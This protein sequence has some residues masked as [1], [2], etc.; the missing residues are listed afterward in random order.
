[1]D[2]LEAIAR[3]HS[4]RQ[5]RPGEVPDRDVE[6]ILQAGRRAPSGY[7]LQN[8]EFVVVRDPDVIAQLNRVQDSFDNVPVVIG[9]VM[10]PGETPSGGSYWVEDCAA[11]V[12]NML[13]AITG[14]GYASVWVEG[15]LRRH[16]SWLKEQLGVPA[17]KRLL[18][19]L[20]VGHEAEPGE[21]AP[22]T[23]LDEL[24][25]YERYGQ[26]KPVVE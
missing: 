16:E 26:K 23:P 15:T 25:H 4:V 6:R 18:V 3:R 24:V 10:T 21:M 11:C 1:M 8:K 14:L 13:L 9:V 19:L 7:N 17:D 5:F 2:V 12:E 22:K 20:P